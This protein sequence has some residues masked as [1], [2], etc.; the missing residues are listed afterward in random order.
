MSTLAAS[1]NGCREVQSRRA[2]NM[3]AQRF[4]YGAAGGT[5]AEGVRLE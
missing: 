3:P 5:G 2:S 1:T 4:G